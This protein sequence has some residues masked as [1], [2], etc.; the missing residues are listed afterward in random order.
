VVAQSG[1]QEAVGGDPAGGFEHLERPADEVGRQRR[2]GQRCQ[3]GAQALG[4]F[5]EAANP[6]LTAPAEFARL[7]QRHIVRE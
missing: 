1:E 7:S 4:L 5:A 6:E 3:R 2:S